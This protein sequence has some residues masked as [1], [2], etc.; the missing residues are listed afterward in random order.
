MPFRCIKFVYLF[1]RHLDASQFRIIATFSALSL[2]SSDTYG[3]RFH[4]TNS[5]QRGNHER[6]SHGYRLQ[7]SSEHVYSLKVKTTRSN[8]FPLFFYFHDT[9][10]L[11]YSAT[12]YFYQRNQ[13]RSRRGAPEIVSGFDAY[14][15]LLFPRNFVCRVFRV[16]PPRFH[17]LHRLNWSHE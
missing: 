17:F 13:T 15:V 5:A 8:Y 7:A 6:W 16:S 14:C 1:E 10:I 9:F 4:K 12:H 11:T 2:R 3:K